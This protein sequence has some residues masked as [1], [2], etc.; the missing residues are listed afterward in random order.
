MKQLD[1]MERQ[2]NSCRS[3][4]N[5][6]EIALKAVRQNGEA[7]EFVS[8]IDQLKYDLYIDPLDKMSLI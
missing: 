4:E 7:I 3:I 2:L 5:D 6:R 8:S 1:E